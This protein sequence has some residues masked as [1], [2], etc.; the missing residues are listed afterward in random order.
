MDRAEYWAA[1]PEL[2]ERIEYFFHLALAS[3]QSGDQIEDLAEFVAGA[4]L[5]DQWQ[6]ACWERII[7]RIKLIS[8]RGDGATAIDEAGA[9]GRAMERLAE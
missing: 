3:A 7:N 4:A 2:N 9:L 5:S 6:H 8:D 1:H